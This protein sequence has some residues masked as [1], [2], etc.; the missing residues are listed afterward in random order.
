[1]PRGWKPTEEDTFEKA[2]RL[3]YERRLEQLGLQADIIITK[4]GDEGENGSVVSS[5]ISHKQG[6]M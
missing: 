3:L 5:N 6:A 4:I 1:M 2:L